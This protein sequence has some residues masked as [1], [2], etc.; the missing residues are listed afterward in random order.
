MKTMKKGASKNNVKKAVYAHE[1]K[2]HP[3]EKKTPLK[4]ALGK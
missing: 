4:K 3:G 2:M 1:S